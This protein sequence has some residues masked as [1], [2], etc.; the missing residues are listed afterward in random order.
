LVKLQA[1]L[2]K[3]EDA[4]LQVVAIS[5]DPV[6][7]LAHFTE[8][9]KVAFPLLS[10]PGSTVIKAFGVLNKEATGDK[11]AGIPYPGI[12][13]VDKD[14]VIRAKLFKEG[15]IQ[16]PTTEEILKSAAEVK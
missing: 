16:R 14:G 11:F 4:G 1:D 6:E 3:F 13:I 9:R 10:D 12:F 15:Y 5:Y 8:Q 7:V 2:K